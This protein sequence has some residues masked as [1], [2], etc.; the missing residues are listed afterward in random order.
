MHISVLFFRAPHYTTSFIL[1]DEDG[2]ATIIDDHLSNGGYSSDEN[3]ED[4][5]SQDVAKS[6]NRS[7]Y[8]TDAQ[9]SMSSGMTIFHMMPSFFDTFYNAL[10]LIYL[11]I[12]Y[13]LYFQIY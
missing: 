9:P 11:K 10:T 7:N 5:A 8:E 12:N 6:S 2:G 4:Y 3:S 13:F 1:D